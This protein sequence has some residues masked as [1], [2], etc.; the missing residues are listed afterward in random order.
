MKTTIEY[1]E[2][3]KKKLGITSDYEFAKRV[4]LKKQSLSR[5]R[6]KQG[7]M[8]DLACVKIAE[9]LGVDPLEIITAANMEREKK[10]ERRRYW[11]KFS[12]RM[13]WV[14]VVIIAVFSAGYGQK[15]G[16][17]IR[18]NEYTLC[19]HSKGGDW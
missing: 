13:G 8:D 4:G 18:A 9:I 14:A 3:A 19:E 5:Y 10:E 17:D 11:E 6:K 16:G 1:L 7:V 15:G 12:R 2:E